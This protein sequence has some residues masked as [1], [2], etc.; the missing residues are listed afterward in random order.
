IKTGIVHKITE[1]NRIP[2][3]WVP[4]ATTE[5][6]LVA[7][8]NRGCL[9]ISK[10]GYGGA[11]TEVVDDGITRAPCIAMPDIHLAFE[12]QQWAERTSGED[13]GFQILFNAFQ[14]TTR[15]GRLTSIK[16]SLAGRLVYLRFKCTT[17]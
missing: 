13:A 10:G 17:G 14:S 12:L 15:H 8:V 3:V 1:T 4:L 16:A 7:S 6:G 2:Q 9:A 11:R 5:G